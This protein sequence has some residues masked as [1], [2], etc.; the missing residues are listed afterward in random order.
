MFLLSEVYRRVIV[1]ELYFHNRIL[2][3]NI[4]IYEETYWLT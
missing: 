2:Q 1:R 4:F 3:T